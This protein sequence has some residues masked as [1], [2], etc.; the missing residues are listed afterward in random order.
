MNN[1]GKNIK[2]LRIGKNMTQDELAS[3]LYVT[4]QT[5]SNYEIG[6]SKPDISMLLRIAEVLETDIHAILY[7]P[8]DSSDR[9]KR[10]LRIVGVISVLVLLGFILYLLNSYAVSHN[11]SPAS[12]SLIFVQLILQPGYYFLMGWQVTA[13]LCAFHIGPLFPRSV[14]K[15]LR[16]CVTVLGIMLIFILFPYYSVM[17]SALGIPYVRVPSLWLSA[18]HFITRNLHFIWIS[19]LL[20]VLWGLGTPIPPSNGKSEES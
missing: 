4:R 17:L 20:G 1:I 2:T 6:K 9:N 12:E 19:L 13:S 3:R 16:G 15:T 14:C 5:V 10:Y 11:Q 7:E 8:Q 18:T